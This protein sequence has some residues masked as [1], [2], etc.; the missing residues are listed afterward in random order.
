MVHWDY[1][2][3]LRPEPGGAELHAA[4]PAV[5]AVLRS[6]SVPRRVWRHASPASGRHTSA[7]YDDNHGNWFDGGKRYTPHVPPDATRQAV[8]VALRSTTRARAAL[9]D[10]PQQVADKSSR[11]PDLAK[12]AR[13]ARSICTWGL[14][15]APRGQGK[16][17]NPDDPGKGLVRGTPPAV[18]ADGSLPR[19]LVEASGHRARP[20]KPEHP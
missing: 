17:R 4:R 8:L 12:N 11:M 16:E 14:H 1:V 6:R 7:S 15:P 9:I 3:D 20:G 19:R 13:R 18:R 2:L 5:R 10:N